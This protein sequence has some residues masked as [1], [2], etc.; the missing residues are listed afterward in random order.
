M[1]RER[2]REGD[3]KYNPQTWFLSVLEETV[4]HVVHLDA[5]GGGQQAQL[6]LDGLHDGLEVGRAVCVLHP[7]VHLQQCVTISIQSTWLLVKKKVRIL[8]NL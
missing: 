5:G 1:F 3:K 4:G 8:N 6:P 2:E 7:R